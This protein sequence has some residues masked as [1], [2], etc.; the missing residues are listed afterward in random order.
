M[1]KKPSEKELIA[2]TD[3]RIK[4]LMRKGHSP[5][6]AKYLLEKKLGKSLGWSKPK[7][8]GEAVYFKGI[9][10]ESTKQRLKKAGLTEKE[11]KTLGIK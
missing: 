1:A 4:K 6:G 11:L 5:A 3:K 9:R 2:R 10:R 7:K 8:R